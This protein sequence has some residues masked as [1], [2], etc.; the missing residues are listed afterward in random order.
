MKF[1]LIALLLAPS[2]AQAASIKCESGNLGDDNYFSVTINQTR[3]AAV[4]FGFHESSLSADASKIVKSGNVIAIVNKKLTGWAEGDRYESL[5]S[6]LLVYSAKEKKLNV[7]LAQEGE[8]V[9]AGEVLS[10]R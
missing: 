3:K 8:V 6:A 5:V 1:A 7:T 10:C 4:E 9:Q 2:F